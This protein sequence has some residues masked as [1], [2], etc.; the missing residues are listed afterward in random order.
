MRK[1]KKRYIIILVIVIIL[2]LGI[3]II[4]KFSLPNVGKIKKGKAHYIDRVVN[5]TKYD[6]KIIIEFENNQELID[7][8]IITTEM[9][10]S[11]KNNDAKYNLSV[12]DYADFRTISAKENYNLNKSMQLGLV[13]ET[14]TYQ[15]YFAFTCGFKNRDELLDYTKAVIKLANKEK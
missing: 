1:I 11:F 9:Y 7:N 5:V 13:K 3:I 4:N 8:C 14:D 15:D 2:I 10:N 6:K 12:R